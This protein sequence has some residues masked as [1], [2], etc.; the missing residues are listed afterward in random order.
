MGGVRRGKSGRAR[1]GRNA[2]TRLK[3]ISRRY[4]T[5]SEIIDHLRGDHD[6]AGPFPLHSLFRLLADDTLRDAIRGDGSRRR[7][8]ELLAGIRN[9]RAWLHPDA[10]D[11]DQFAV[12]IFSETSEYPAFDRCELRMDRLAYQPPRLTIDYEQC[13]DGVGRKQLPDLFGVSDEG[14]KTRKRLSGAGVETFG[15]HRRW[16]DLIGERA[17]NVKLTEPIVVEIR[18]RYAAGGISMAKLGKQYGVSQAT[19]NGIVWGSLWIYAPGPVKQRQL[20]RA[21]CTASGMYLNKFGERTRTEDHPKPD[22]LNSDEARVLNECDQQ[23]EAERYVSR[24]EVEAW[25]GKTPIQYD[26]GVYNP[27]AD[28]GEGHGGDLGADT[29]QTGRV[30]GH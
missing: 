23:R 5:A 20:L 4:K 27:Q 6:Y 29:P 30:V 8:A 11:D 2:A 15:K 14:G 12:F 9:Y 26:W 19:I 7:A 3:N 18:E 13:L 17:P 10:N 24:A 21:R 1:S 16:Q 22:A 25:R 28:N